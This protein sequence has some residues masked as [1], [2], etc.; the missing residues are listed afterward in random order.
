LLTGQIN[1]ENPDRNYKLSN[2]ESTARYKHHMYEMT[3]CYF[4]ECLR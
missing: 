3:G 1:V 2:I 4:Q